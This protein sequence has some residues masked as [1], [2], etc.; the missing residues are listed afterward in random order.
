[1]PFVPK[2]PD[3]CR[4]LDLAHVSRTLAKHYGYFPSAARE[5]GVSAAG[6]R[7]LTWAKPKLL[8]EAHEK[9]ELTVL[10]GRGELIRALFSDN[11]RRRMWGADRILSSWMARDSPHARATRLE[12]RGRAKATIVTSFQEEPGATV[13]ERDGKSIR[14]P[15][16]DGGRGGD[17][18]ESKAAPPAVLIEQ[19]ARLSLPVWPG[20]GLRPPLLMI[21]R[22]APPRP[23]PA[24]LR[25]RLPVCRNS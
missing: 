8:D 12:T 4:D 23:R 21:H 22:E 6:L 19:P 3:S 5:L 13:I 11:V 1:M 25:R 10:R 17:C 24:V 2:I 16:Y 9:M 7:R 20:P 18:V 14:V 15:R